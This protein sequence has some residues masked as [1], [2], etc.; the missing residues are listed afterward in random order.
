MGVAHLE[1]GEPRAALRC[2]RRALAADRHDLNARFNAG[3]LLLELRRLRGLAAL[4]DDAPDDVMAD[5]SMRRLAEELEEARGLGSEG[6]GADD[7]LNAHA[8]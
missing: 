2:Y 3:E 8:A 6:D 4:L 7:S 5:E 1:L